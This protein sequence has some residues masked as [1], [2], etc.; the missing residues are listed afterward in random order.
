MTD[1]EFWQ[2]VYPSDGREPDPEDDQPD[3]PAVGFLDAPCLTCGTIG[4][5][6]YDANGLPLVHAEGDDA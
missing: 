5:C 3:P 2:D 1:E 4:P 6:A